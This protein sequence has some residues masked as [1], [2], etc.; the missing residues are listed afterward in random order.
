MERG[1]GEF[2]S[3]GQRGPERTPVGGIWLPRTSRVSGMLQRQPAPSPDQ[4]AIYGAS[5]LGLVCVCVCVQKI[6]WHRKPLMKPN[7]SRSWHAWKRWWIHQPLPRA[8]RCLFLLF[9]INLKEI[10]RYKKKSMCL[11][12]NWVDGT[13]VGTSQ[14]VGWMELRN[15]NKK[16]R[17][18]NWDC[19]YWQ[20]LGR[21]NSYLHKRN[22]FHLPTLS[23]VIW[24]F[25]PQYLTFP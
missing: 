2:I 12:L 6:Y 23:R 13:T 3:H 17:K 8:K 1:R 16:K 22:I 19:K 7:Q 14:E 24:G 9:S 20:P 15:E 5:P 25:Q 18:Q 4:E 11:A 21:K 10:W